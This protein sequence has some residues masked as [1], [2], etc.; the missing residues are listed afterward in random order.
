MELKRN[1]GDDGECF[2]DR[3]L[4]G[5]LIFQDEDLDRAANRVMVT[6]TGIRSLKLTQ[7]RVYGPLGRT[8]DP[9]DIMWLER[10][11]SVHADR[12]ITVA[13]MALTRKWNYMRVKENLVWVPIDQL[14]L[15][16][17][18]HSR[19]IQDARS[20]LSDYVVRE[21]EVLFRILPH[22]FTASQFRKVYNLLMNRDVDSPNIYKKIKI[23]PYVVEHKQI[24]KSSLSR[25]THYYRFDSKKYKKYRM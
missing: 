7:F 5:G 20:F 1:W 10:V 22:L 13:Y 12:I 18:D 4:P 11:H 16:A 8:K 23:I 25:A 19:I 3:K 24:D 21:P 17:F 15:L 14:P 6:Q 2:S 9:K